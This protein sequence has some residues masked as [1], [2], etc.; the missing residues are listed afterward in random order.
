HQQ[1]GIPM[2]QIAGQERD[3]L[4]RMEEILH[5]RVIGQD[6][7]ISALARAVRRAR[8]G[9]KDP[10]RPIGSFLFLG[11][12][13]VGKTESAL[14]LAEFLFGA[15]DA[16]VMLNMSEYMEKHNAA[17]LIGAPPGYVGYEEGGQLTE[18]V[19]QRPYSVVVLDEVEKSHPD[20]YDLFLQV[21]DQGQLQDSRGRVVSFRNTVVVMTSNLGGRALAYPQELPPGVDPKSA[22]MDAVRD[23][24][25]PEFLNRL[26]GVIVFDPLDRESL[27]KILDLMLAK[28]GRQLAPQGISLEV[29]QAARNWL[30]EQHVEP[31]YGA[32]PL[33]RI[34][35]TFVKDEMAERLV[36]GTLTPGK[37]VVLGIR[38][39]KLEFRAED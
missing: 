29:T 36:N 9:L 3:R 8:A 16:V 27:S 33:T 32:R 2:G 19:R 1:T 18:K 12:S 34:V 39:G 13:G 14:A 7:A 21:F 30:L 22:V 37:K 6:A 11:P 26:D 25:R 4:A 35:Q 38:E 17:R 5:Q 31:E 10:K 28:A 15:E 23:H 24:F 20:V